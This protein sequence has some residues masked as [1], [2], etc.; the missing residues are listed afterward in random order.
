MAARGHAEL[1][2]EWRPGFILTRLSHGNWPVH[3]LRLV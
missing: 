3:D 1:A 2:S